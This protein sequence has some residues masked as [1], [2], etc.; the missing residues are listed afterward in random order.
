M[1]NFHIVRLIVEM[2]FIFF[3]VSF[4]SAF[5]LGCDVGMMAGSETDKT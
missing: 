2:T 4:S 3:V 5:L 1:L